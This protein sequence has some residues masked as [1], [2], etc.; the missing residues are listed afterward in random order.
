ML[1]T[2][3][4]KPEAFILIED[5]SSKLP[6][7][8]GATSQVKDLLQFEVSCLS[9]GAEFV[10][11]VLLIPTVNV[12]DSVLAEILPFKTDSTF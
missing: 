11:F 3:E 5:D 9:K 4:P 12:E 1:D 6:W 8:V 2:V 10:N 7:C